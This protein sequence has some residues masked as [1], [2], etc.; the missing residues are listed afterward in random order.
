MKRRKE[1]RNE[2]MNEGRE[3]RDIQKRKEKTLKL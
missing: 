3:V 2:K 1:E